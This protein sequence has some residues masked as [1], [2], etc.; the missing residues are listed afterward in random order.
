MELMITAGK[1]DHEVNWELQNIKFV[2]SWTKNKIKRERLREKSKGKT[3]KEEFGTE[4]KNKEEFW[5]NPIS[6]F[7]L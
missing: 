3:K 2:F 1:T 5:M 7:L 6:I 4:K